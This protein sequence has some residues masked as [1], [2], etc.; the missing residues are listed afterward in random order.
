[1]VPEAPLEPTEE[2][3]LLTG[4]GWFVLNARDAQWRRWTGMGTWP[5]LEGA[6]PRYPQLGVGLTVLEP[7]EPMAMY[8]WETVQEDFLVL[9]GEA[10]AIVEG[11]ERPMRKGDF[12][13]LPAGT[14][15]IAVG[16]GDGPCSI[17]MVGSRKPEERLFYPVDESAARHGASSEQETT[18]E[19][20][21]YAGS[22]RPEPVGFGL[23]W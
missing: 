5:R 18:D 7:G 1:V 2:G 14:A 13:H 20:V 10:L 9:A 6:T 3:L 21:A 19:T 12:L 16:A 22:P 11:Q 23:P 4:D 8:H 17:L 15:H